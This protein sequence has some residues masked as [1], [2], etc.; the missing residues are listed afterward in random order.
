MQGL[1]AARKGHR[2]G[3]QESMQ[4]KGVLHDE[5]AKQICPD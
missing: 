2:I 3:F 5:G 4:E 1:A